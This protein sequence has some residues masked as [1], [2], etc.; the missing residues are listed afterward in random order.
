[1]S[2]LTWKWNGI[3]GASLQDAL[4]FAAT[5]KKNDLE[6]PLHAYL[7]IGVD[8]GESLKTVLDIARPTHVALVDIW[9]PRY[10][11]H[12]YGDERHIRRIFSE[13]GLDHGIAQFVNGDSHITI[14]TQ[15]RGRAFELITVDGDHTDAGLLADLTD[16]WPL[17]RAKGL[18][19]VDDI[20][21]IEYP[22]L[23]GVFDRWLA[24]T[25]E[26]ELIPEI[27]N[28]VEIT[29]NPPGGKWLPGYAA[30]TRVVRRK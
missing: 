10:C 3:E 7:E 29:P 24:S 23:K 1:M 21:H 13:R 19:V 25:P 9:D 14:K 18:M 30:T 26:A 8:G 11:N 6:F 15:L 22:G 2:Q 16:S 27:D 5:H 17:L 12:G 4:V 20:G 28:G